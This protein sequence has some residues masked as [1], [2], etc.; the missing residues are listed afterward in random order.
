MAKR[1]YLCP[2]VGD[3]TYGNPYRPKVADYPVSW[4]GVMPTNAAGKPTAAWALVRVAAAN[5]VAVMADPQID[6]L[7]NL[8]LDGKVASLSAAVK[9]AL[10]TRL[11]ALGIATDVLDRADGYRDLVRAIGRR[12]QADFD[13]EKLD[14]AE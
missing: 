7:P 14:V 6:A 13:E 1:F 11:T 2:V 8:D 4:S 12:L 10:R 9:T 5:H 3:G